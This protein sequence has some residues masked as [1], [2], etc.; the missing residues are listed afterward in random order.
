MQSPTSALEPPPPHPPMT[1]RT[2]P[3]QVSTR[4]LLIEPLMSPSLI[5]RRLAYLV[6]APR[7]VFTVPRQ[8]WKHGNCDA[9]RRAPAR[10]ARLLIRGR[11]LER[12][13]R[14]HWALG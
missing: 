2:P 5:D 12:G 4:I 1:K 14:P 11:V 8:I 7:R 13:G 9:H 10:T 3:R 6:P